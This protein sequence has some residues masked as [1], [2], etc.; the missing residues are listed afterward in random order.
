MNSAKKIKYNPIR[1][2]HK[3]LEGKTASKLMVFSILILLSKSKKTL[4]D[5]FQRN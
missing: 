5:C 4:I 3:D 2:N 1:A